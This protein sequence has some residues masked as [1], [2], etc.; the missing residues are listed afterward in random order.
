MCDI[1]L[2][3]TNAHE[4]FI[5]SLQHWIRHLKHYRTC[6]VY[7]CVLQFKASVTLCLM[8]GTPTHTTARNTSSACITW[9]LCAAALNHWQRRHCTTTPTA[10]I[11]IIPTTWNLL[12]LHNAVCHCLIHG[13]LQAGVQVLSKPWEQ[14]SITAIH[15]NSEMMF[16]CRWKQNREMSENEETLGA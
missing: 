6:D 1:Y 10:E 5:P 11:A 2:Q 4:L 13:L 15:L 12:E 7:N 8:V 14:S 9:R 3:Q 16:C